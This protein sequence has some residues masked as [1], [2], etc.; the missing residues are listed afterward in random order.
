MVT[1]E[2]LA[3]DPRIKQLAKDLESPQ[4]AKFIADKYNGSVIPVAAAGDKS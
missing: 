4:V 2:K 3:S 1:T